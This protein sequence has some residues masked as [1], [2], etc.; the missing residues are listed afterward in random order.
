MMWICRLCWRKG[1]LIVN[2]PLKE[3][4]RVGAHNHRYL[5]DLDMR[6]GKVPAGMEDYS[7]APFMEKYPGVYCA[8]DIRIGN[9]SSIKQKYNK[10]QNPEFQFGEQE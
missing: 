5:V 6:A 8:G 10:K 7:N 4:L 3:A 1:K 9:P 2:M